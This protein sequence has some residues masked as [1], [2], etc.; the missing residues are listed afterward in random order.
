MDS[1][2]AL[3]ARVKR[4]D[5]VAFDDLYARYARRLFGFLRPQLPTRADAEDVFHE[6][7]LAA[8]ESD[9]VVF[10]RGSFRAWLF[11]IARNLVLNRVRSDGRGDAAMA[12][13]APLADEPPPAADER[14]HQGQMLRAL[15]G[16]VA[17]LPSPLS[18]IYHLRSSGLSYEEM[19]V[20][21]N[22]PLGTLKSRMN[23]MVNVLREELKPWT[24]R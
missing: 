20:V 17:R 8:L 6:S 19:A 16:A 2:E 13:L 14:A 9:E 11:R 24:A 7:L 4:G 18:E 12:K 23:Q 3:Y 21:L 10:D 5:M 1:D 22:I 15:D